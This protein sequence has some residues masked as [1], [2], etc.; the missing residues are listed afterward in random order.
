MT[1]QQ[2]N[3]LSGNLGKLYLNDFQLKKFI[4]VVGLAH[5]FC[6]DFGPL[7][8]VFKKVIFRKRSTAYS[9]VLANEI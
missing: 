2:N 7:L 6:F 4:W 9:Q 8:D 5:Q 3:L 1:E